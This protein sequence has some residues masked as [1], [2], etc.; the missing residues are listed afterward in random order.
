MRAGTRLTEAALTA[1]ERK[2]LRL[3]AQAKSNQEIGEALAMSER[4]VRYYLRNICDKLGLTGR[5]E[6]IAWAI[7]HGLDES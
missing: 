5:C 3:L 6:A 2:V 1:R 7:R 4:T